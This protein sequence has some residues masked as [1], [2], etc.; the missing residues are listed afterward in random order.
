ML[1]V[2]F[3][4]PTEDRQPT[5]ENRVWTTEC[6]WVPIALYLVHILQFFTILNKLLKMCV[7][8]VAH[9]P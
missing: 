5:T 6:C 3:L 1:V 7:K 8:H 9:K 2:D 4:M